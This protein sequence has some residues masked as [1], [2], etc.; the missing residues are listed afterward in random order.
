M[1]IVGYTQIALRHFLQVMVKK[2]FSAFQKDG[3]L[4]R[5]FHRHFV[6]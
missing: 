4:A 2:V 3:V 6:A 1:V 5:F